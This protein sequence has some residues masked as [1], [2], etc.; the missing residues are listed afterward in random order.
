MANGRN[1]KNDETSTVSSLLSLAY[2]EIRNSE[3][4][5][6]IYKN[7]VITNGVLCNE[8]DKQDQCLRFLKFKGTRLFWID[9]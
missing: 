1:M 2:T 4:L 5:I 9:F 6:V 3:R 7:G 8:N